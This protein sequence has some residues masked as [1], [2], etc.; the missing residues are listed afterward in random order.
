MQA[1]AACVRPGYRQQR[2]ALKRNYRHKKTD[3]EVG[4]FDKNVA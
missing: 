1:R 3:P 2:P 4:F